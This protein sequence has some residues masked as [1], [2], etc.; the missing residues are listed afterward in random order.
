MLA[1]IH[2]NNFY[3]YLNVPSWSISCEW[4]FYLL[5]PAAMFCVLGSMRRRMLLVGIIAVYVSALMLFL[6]HSQSEFARAYFLN[7]FA[8]SRFVDFLAGVFLARLFMAPRAYRWAAFSVPAQICGLTYLVGVVFWRDYAPWPLSGGLIYVPGAA[9]L[10]FGLA[11]SRGIFAAHLSGPWLR[12]LGMASFS[13]YMLHTPMMRALKGVYYYFGWETRTWAGFWSVALTAYIVIQTAAFIMLYNFELPTQK[14][15]RG[16]RT[17]PAA[18]T[19]S[20][21]ILKPSRRFENVHTLPADSTVWE[22]LV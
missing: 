8:P 7:W 3:N 1:A 19:G 13:F 14:W 15:L 20:S 9:L 17:Q 6:W 21:E 4:F 18:T 22:K 16:L 10:V 2:E 11:H 5:A 12:R